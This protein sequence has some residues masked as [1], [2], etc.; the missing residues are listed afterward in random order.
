M[1]LRLITGAVRS[2]ILQHYRLK[3]S[4]C[5]W[6][7]IQGRNID[8]PANMLKPC[9]EKEKSES[10]SFGWVILKLAEEMEI[11]EMPVNPTVPQ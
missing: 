8:H 3:Q 7:S 2:T 5:P 9:W 4:K 6:V 10:R 11:S 1:A